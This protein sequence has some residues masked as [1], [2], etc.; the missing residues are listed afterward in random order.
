MF[1]FD[2]WSL[3]VPLA[4]ISGYW[5]GVY[6]A[7]KAGLSERRMENALLWAICVGLFISHV[8]EILLY[9]PHKLEKEGFLTLFK[10]WDGLSSFGGF[11]G[12]TAALFV[13][14]A[15]HKR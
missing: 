12:G 8:V 2:F 7:Q 1:R 11:G 14:F 6:R 3:A 10:F 4:I 15:F 9:Q 5:I 13:F